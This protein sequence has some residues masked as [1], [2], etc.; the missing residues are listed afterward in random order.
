MQSIDLKPLYVKE[1]KRYS[2]DFFKN[3]NVNMDLLNTLKQEDYLTYDDGFYIFKYVG[4]ILVENRVIH[5]YPKYFSL[6][7]DN[8]LSDKFKQVLQVIKKYN[9]TE[10]VDYDYL[11]SDQTSS[12][13]LPLML[14]FIEDYYEHGIYTNYKTIHQINGNG[15]IN[16]DRTINNYNPVIIKNKPY[17]MELETRYNKEDT[18]DIF[19]QLHKCIITQ[20]SKKLEITG[21]LDIFDLTPANISDKSLNS[22]FSQGILKRIEQEQKI[23]FN[24]HKQKL[25]RYM[26]AI[27][28][29]EDLFGDN[30]NLSLY[31]TNSF[32]M[33]WEKV[34]QNV[35][36]DVL[37]KKILK[38]QKENLL[39]NKNKDYTEYGKKNL[40]EIIDKPEWTFE[41]LGSLNIYDEEKYK[42]HIK[43]NTLKPDLILFYKK[44]FIVLDAKYYVYKIDENKNKLSKQPGIESVTKQYLYELA[45]KDFIEY[46]GF[47][48]S[49]NGF[50]FPSDKEEFEN[51]GFVKLNFLSKLVKENN[52]TFN[53][54]ENIQLLLLPATKMYKRYL[55]NK[56]LTNLSK[57]KIKG[58][59]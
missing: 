17:Y 28:K 15:E 30:E 43:K 4:I 58:L 36:G 37:E 11:D 31:G 45:Y 33:V 18:Y 41:K 57:L 8:K 53:D 27:L 10:N 3:N 5:C 22:F 14:F 20:C 29:K 39:P 24:T 13:L 21:L 42:N 12:N 51:V 7:N 25:L 52:K 44:N 6:E 59:T 9:K 23:E 50:L 49:K 46:A 34:C 48:N 32:N 56:P 1:L 55:N 19:Q 26:H 16:W 2:E 35:L 38:L 47:K 54:E 40:K